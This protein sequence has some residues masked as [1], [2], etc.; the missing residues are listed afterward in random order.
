MTTI[1]R[2]LFVRTFIQQTFTRSGWVQF[3]RLHSHKTQSQ[4]KQCRIQ[5]GSS[6]DCVRCYESDTRILFFFGFVWGAYW[7][8]CVHFDSNASA[9]VM[10]N[11]FCLWLKHQMNITTAIQ[12][13]TIECITENGLENWYRW[14][15]I[16]VG[17]VKRHM[18]FRLWWFI[19][20]SIPHNILFDINSFEY[21]LIYGVRCE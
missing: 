5:Y 21:F 20:T 3:V 14:T 18:R 4:C 19:E 9:N 10:A 11:T 15:P 6:M 17:L 1:C 7:C 13:W 16:A 8:D 2:T 12:M